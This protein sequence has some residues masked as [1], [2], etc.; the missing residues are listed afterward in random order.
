MASKKLTRRG[1]LGSTAGVGLGGFA[2][3]SFPV[4][5]VPEGGT[6]NAIPVGHEYRQDDLPSIAASPDGTM[7]VAW[8]SFNG[9]RD[10]VAIRAYKKGV[11]ENLQWV[12]GT[13]GDSWLPHVAVDPSNRVWVVWSQ[14]VAGNW[15]LYARQFDPATESWS[16]LHKLTSDPL[17]DINPFVWSDGKG[18]AA[19]VWQGFRRH[20]PPS[21]RA[22]CNI[23]LRTLEGDAWSEEI[24]VTNR[25]ANDWEPTIALDRS[26]T[27]WVAYDSYK[28]GRYDI[29]LTPVRGGQ[30]G[31]EVAVAATPRFDARASVA[32]DT[33]ER[34]WVAWESGHENWG[35]DFGRILG[36]HQVGVP[37]GGFREFKI[38]CYD[39]GAWLEPQ[40]PLAA[41]LGGADTY[42]PHVFSDGSGSVWVVGLVRKYATHRP[43]YPE[44]EAF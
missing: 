36:D 40:A 33:A 39:H 10:D 25:E 23:F 34:V 29:Y 19:I 12:P 30:A 3:P 11:W 7:W 8:L 5:W 28:N 15:D 1:F 41:M 43:A 17:P 37:L 26:G 18:G 14:Q 6:V 27:A 35:K 13:S 20:A 22:S 21:T 4:Q 2:I 38:R 42:R 24:R 9:D 32:I 31:A 16:A 44:K